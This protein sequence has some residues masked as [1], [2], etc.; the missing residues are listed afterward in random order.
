MVYVVQEDEVSKALGGDGMTGV[1]STR[2]ETGKSKDLLTHDLFIVDIL[3]CM[4]SL[5]R[6]WSVE[7]VLKVVCCSLDHNQADNIL[8]ITLNSRL[9]AT[10]C[11][12]LRDG[13]VDALQLVVTVILLLAFERTRAGTILAAFSSELTGALKRNSHDPD[14]I[15]EKVMPVEVVLFAAEFLVSFRQSELE[16]PLDKAVAA[17]HPF[18]T[19]ASSGSSGAGTALVDKAIVPAL[20]FMLNYDGGPRERLRETAKVYNRSD[21]VDT[22]RCGAHVLRFL[23]T[24]S[25][26]LFGFTAAPVVIPDFCLLVGNLLKS[27]QGQL[28]TTSEN[29]CQDQARILRSFRS[30]PGLQ[31]SGGIM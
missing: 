1:L 15:D 23:N 28:E 5:P 25:A 4:M 20:Q 18:L 8:G 9:Q 7:T 3:R 6:K 31:V 21:C 10:S 13:A 30:F 24:L 26:C 14:V 16:Y 19:V 22:N 17:L 2:K 27:P 12:A 29:L 11:E